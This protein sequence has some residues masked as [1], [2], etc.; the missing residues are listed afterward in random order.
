MSVVLGIEFNIYNHLLSGDE[1]TYI[2][3]K[4]KIGRFAIGGIDNY[5]RFYIYDHRHDEN[6]EDK[7]F[8]VEAINDGDSYYFK[9]IFSDDKILIYSEDY[10]YGDNSESFIG[11][12]KIS[13][14]RQH[15]ALCGSYG[16][17]LYHHLNPNYVMEQEELV[18]EHPL[19]IGVA[20]LRYLSEFINSDAI[21][22]FNKKYAKELAMDLDAMKL[23]A[24]EELLRDYARLNP[25]RG[26]VKRYFY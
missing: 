19:A 20:D 10:M 17:S 2:I 12:I 25:D 15:Q 14:N 18:T 9:P 22:E 8:V 23:T 26:K 3:E 16:P 1:S 4:S 13:N 5:P 7:Q 24:S 11:E 6:Y 21:I